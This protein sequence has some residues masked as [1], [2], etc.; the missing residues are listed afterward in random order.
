MSYPGIR[1]VG[2]IVGTKTKQCL[3]LQI[4][5]KNLNC[6]CTYRLQPFDLQVR[7]GGSGWWMAVRWY[8]AS[9]K[10]GGDS[11]RTDT[12]KVS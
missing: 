5:Q 10:G 9:G 6:T 12:G 2:L 11:F 4:L 7:G 3:S 1:S 8:L